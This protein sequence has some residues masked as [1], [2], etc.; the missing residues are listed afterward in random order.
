MSPPGWRGIPAFKNISC[1]R[2]RRGKCDGVT[3]CWTVE[4][5]ITH[6]CAATLFIRHCVRQPLCVDRHVAI[7]WRGSGAILR[8]TIW[9]SE[10]ALECKTCS[11]GSGRQCHC[12][13]GDKCCICY[14]GTT[15]LLVRHVINKSPSCNQFNI[16][17]CWRMRRCQCAAAS[18]CS[19]PTEKRIS[20]A[21]WRGR[22]CDGSTL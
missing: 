9:C 21:R 11:S 19:E 8:S 6:R 3:S 13:A 12:A 7:W 20:S 2:W 10:P 15:A 17:T 1:P 5:C 14:C 16:A 4:C 18:C 22:Q